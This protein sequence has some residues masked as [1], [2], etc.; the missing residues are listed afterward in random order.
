[1]L[2]QVTLGLQAA[3]GELN[4]TWQTSVRFMKNVE[5]DFSGVIETALGYPKFFRG[6]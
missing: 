6:H 5:G 4:N 3:G 2:F 1:M